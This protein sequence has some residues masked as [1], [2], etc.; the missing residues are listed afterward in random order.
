[1]TFMRDQ[2]NGAENGGWNLCLMEPLYGSV[3]IVA[4]RRERLVTDPAP[5][6]TEEK[7]IERQDYIRFPG[8]GKQPL[9]GNAQQAAS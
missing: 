5:V 2:K 1:M 9:A 8:P 4:N 7:L 3:L 6:Q